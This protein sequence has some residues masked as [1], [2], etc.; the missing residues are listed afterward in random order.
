MRACI[1]RK[2][3]A[4]Q[5]GRPC[6]TEDVDAASDRRCTLGGLPRPRPR[7]ASGSRGRTPL[8]RLCCNSRNRVAHGHGQCMYISASPS[9]QH[10]AIGGGG[11]PVHRALCA[12]LVSAKAC[13]LATN[14]CAGRCTR[15]A[16]TA[17]PLRGVHRR[18]LGQGKRYSAC[19]LA[20]NKAV[21]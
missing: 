9:L 5:H 11:M 3:P 15:M 21:R 18:A 19:Q 12:Q 8:V 1:C 7:P 17:Q 2:T 13:R 20:K 16:C 14:Y 6:A 10:K 4:A